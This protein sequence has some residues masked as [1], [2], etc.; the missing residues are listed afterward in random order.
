MVPV[1]VSGLYSGM[2]GDAICSV[3]QA[4]GLGGHIV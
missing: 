4:G 2:G 1:R 3:S